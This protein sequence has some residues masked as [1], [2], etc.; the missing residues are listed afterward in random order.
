MI[1]VMGKSYSGHPGYIPTFTQ[2]TEASRRW[3]P[4]QQRGLCTHKTGADNFWTYRLTRTREY[5]QRHRRW[6][7]VVNGGAHKKPEPANNERSEGKKP[8]EVDNVRRS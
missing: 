2:L 6:T 4:K 5:T 3:F 7:T 8:I 1:L